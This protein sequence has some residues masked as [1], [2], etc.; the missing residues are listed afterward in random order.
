MK[1]HQAKGKKW[2][3]VVRRKGK[4]ASGGGPQPSPAYCLT[5]L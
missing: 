1:L 5:K 2:V 4:R 3:T